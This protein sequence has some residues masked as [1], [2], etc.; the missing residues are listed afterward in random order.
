MFR[1]VIYPSIL[2]LINLSFILWQVDS[3]IIKITL[4]SIS[5][6][7][8]FSF[9]YFFTKKDTQSA[10]PKLTTS[11]RDY[12]TAHGL[13]PREITFFRH[14]MNTLKQ[15]IIEIIAWSQKDKRLSMLFKRYQ[16]EALLKSY[17]HSIVQY[18]EHLNNAGK[19]IYQS[20]PK[21][22]Q[23]I[24][25]YNQLSIPNTTNNIKEQHVLRRDIDQLMARI[26]QEYTQFNVER[27]I[28]NDN[29]KE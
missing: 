19:F 12:Y 5:F 16:G 11:K 14:E 2:F 26:Q 15:F 18:P 29:N 10:I 3:P 21:L 27:K 4:G 28:T 22:H 7:I 20:I 25:H 24:E 1:K 23:L 17:F 6:I 8:I 13:S 9:Y